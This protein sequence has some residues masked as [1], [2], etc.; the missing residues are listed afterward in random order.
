VAHPT[1]KRTLLAMAKS[2]EKLAVQAEA[3]TDT[4]G[5][6]TRHNSN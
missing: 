3:I 2:Y 6:P 4:K 5:S 1:A